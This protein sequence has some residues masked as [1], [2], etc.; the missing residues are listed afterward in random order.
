[1]LNLYA[2]YTFIYNMCACG[3]HV[4]GGNNANDVT[5]AAE[6]N[7]CVL[8]G[9]VHIIHIIHTHIGMYATVVGTA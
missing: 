6:L 2:I 1:M 5:A 8:V 4:H 3:R 7:M 9:R